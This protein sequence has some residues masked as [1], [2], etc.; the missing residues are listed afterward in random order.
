MLTRRLC[1]AATTATLLS[2]AG[3][4]MN[5]TSSKLLSAAQ[6]S[7]IDEELFQSFSVDSLM[8]LA[9]LSVAAAIADAYPK[10]SHMRPLVVCGP[11]NNGGDGLV[12]ARHLCH[13][14]YRPVVVYPKRPQTPLFINLARQMEH[15][16]IPLLHEMPSEV[17]A[18]HDVIIDAI[19]GFSF[20][21]G[22]L[23]APFDAIIP[24]MK[25]SKLPLVSIDVPSGWDVDNGP[26]GDGAAL[27]PD[28]LISLTGPKLCAA[29]FTGS[30][31]YLGGRF[32][33]PSIL[34]KYGFAQPAF[35]GTEQVVRLF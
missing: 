10:S 29:K 17:D 3:V 5:A 21:A 32:V 20:K 19:F 2:W 7:A 26:T 6:A 9:G 22:G 28:V 8:E 23:R 1:R 4:T 14:G 18:E 25:S 15:L 13:F 16:G 24:R 34:S 27:E 33:P 35:P 31:H 12:A 30:R 11:G